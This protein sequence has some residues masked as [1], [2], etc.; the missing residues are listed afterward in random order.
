MR[1]SCCS[2]S[3]SLFTARWMLPGPN[4]ILMKAI[5]FLR[6]HQAQRETNL[7][8]QIKTVCA[9]QA[10]LALAR[11]SVSTF[12]AARDWYVVGSRV[13][14]GLSLKPHCLIRRDPKGAG[15]ADCQTDP[16][17]RKAEQL[18][19]SA[20]NHKKPGGCCVEVTEPSL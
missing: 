13:G 1:K 4:L 19:D 17:P 10:L 14:A 18:E 11:P 12:P 20:G 6:K 9:S 8:L 15:S 3:I 7:I 16:S 2:A 5:S